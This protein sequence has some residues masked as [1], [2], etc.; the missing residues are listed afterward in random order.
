MAKYY[1]FL[2][3][4]ENLDREFWLTIGIYADSAEEAKNQLFQVLIET[5]LDGGSSDAVFE[6][7][8]E[9]ALADDEAPA[10]MIYGSLPEKNVSW[11]RSY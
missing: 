8:Y 1:T 9:R 3:G 10:R 7:V 11:E 4:S 5:P 2:S 6:F